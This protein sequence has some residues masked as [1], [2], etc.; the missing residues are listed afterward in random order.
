MDQFLQAMTKNGIRHTTSAPYHQASNGLAERAVQTWKNGLRKVSQGSLETRLSRVLFQYRITPHATTGKS[1]AELLMGRRLRS[2]L[3]QLHPDVARQ[4]RR[5][6]ERQ[7]REHD[8][9]AVGRT[10]SIG[11]A[12]LTRNYSQG[13]KWLKGSVV[14]MSGSHSLVVCMENGQEVCRHIDQVRH[15]L[16]PARQDTPI[17]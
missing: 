7:K 17:E 13:P 5:S 8:K 1:P 11:D 9:T 10:F 3:D 14:Q 2:H 4:V 15:R 12:V 16:E 6:Q